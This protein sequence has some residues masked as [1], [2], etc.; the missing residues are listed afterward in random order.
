MIMDVEERFAKAAQ[1]F[2]D[3]LKGMEAAAER[4]APVHEVEQSVWKN[5]QEVSREEIA[6]YIAMQD[7]ES[8]PPEIEVEGK[9]LRR[10]KEKR[11]RSYLSAFG[12]IS[13]QRYVY[14]TRETQRQEV[15]PLDAKLGM[16]KG[17][18]SYLLENW[19][20]AD[21]T[22]DSYQQARES[23]CGSSASP[24]RFMAWKGW[25]RDCPSSPRR[26]WR[27]KSR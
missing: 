27:T 22:G 18:T 9:R 25:S 8:Y 11:R 20:G 16:P 13:F 17:E 12:P 26:S 5:M 14:A 10:L 3:G 23:F 15:I 2:L 1:R 24:L 4:G 6:A 19:L 7:V 21:C